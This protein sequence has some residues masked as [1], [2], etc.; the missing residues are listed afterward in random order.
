MEKKTLKQCQNLREI[1]D[2]NAR[3]WDPENTSDHR[4][5]IIELETD[6]QPIQY[7]KPEKK[8]N[9]NWDKDND[10]QMYQ[11]EL[12]KHLE[13]RKLKDPDSLKTKLSNSE[14][15]SICSILKPL[16]RSTLVN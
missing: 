1:N 8:V 10:Q 16:A 5:I 12:S 2:I 13:K 11:T 3:L 9:I 14:K 7:E 4:A 6:R 15:P